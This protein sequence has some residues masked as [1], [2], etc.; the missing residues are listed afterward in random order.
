MN[1]KLFFSFLS[2]ITS[3]P[4]FSLSPLLPVPLYPHISPHI[5]IH[6]SKNKNNN[7]NAFPRKKNKTKTKQTKKNM[8]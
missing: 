6:P 4:Y 5:Q 8:V 3:G 2:Y 7:K 1:E